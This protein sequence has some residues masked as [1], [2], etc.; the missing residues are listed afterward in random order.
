MRFAGIERDDHAFMLKIDFY[1]FH[2]GNFLQYRAQLAHAFI[3]IFAFSGDLDRFQD[4]VVGSFR[5]KRI[6]WIGIVWSRRIHR[7]L[8]F[9]YLTCDS[10]AAVAS[11]TLS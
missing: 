7:F 1:V 10:R 8:I 5:E 11:R 6:G 4:R 2:P 9:I 3:A